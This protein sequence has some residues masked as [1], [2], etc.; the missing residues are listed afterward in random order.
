MYTH[1]GDNLIIKN[2]DVIGIFDVKS[3][4]ASRENKRVQFEMKENNLTG[5]SV[6]LMQDGKKY[7]ETFSPISVSTLK[8]R[9]EKGII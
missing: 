8:K 3:I 1:I 7:K 9:L 6:I 2:R 4:E 5:K